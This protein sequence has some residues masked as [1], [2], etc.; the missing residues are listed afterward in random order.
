MIPELCEY[1]QWVLWRRV[2]VNGRKAKLPLSPWS[3]KAAACDKPQTWSTYQHVRYAMRRHRADGLGSVFTDTDPFCGIDLDR[4]RDANGII[5]ACARNLITRF[6]SYT[7]LSPS[8]AGVHILIKAKLQGGGRRAG[9]IEMYDSGRY[10]TMTGRHIAETPLEIQSRQ[11]ALIQLIA[12]LG[13]RAEANCFPVIATPLDTSD[14]E[15]LERAKLARNGERFR[16]LW[17]GD[18]SDYE[19]DHSRA[20]IA[21]CRM[22]MFWCGGD[23]ERVDRLF[24]QSGLMRDKWDRK[25]GETTYGTKT[26]LAL[27]PTALGCQK[28]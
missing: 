28:G 27:G 16:R 17:A 24:R 9:N 12:K 3:G 22:L 18:A 10:F 4:C 11:E 26:L 23:L 5:D 14:H 2:D 20:D 6:A 7:E 15:V 1:K 8:G 19:N 25:T 13:S 21:L